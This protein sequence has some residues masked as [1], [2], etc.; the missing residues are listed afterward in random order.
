MLYE[1]VRN[2]KGVFQKIIE[3]RKTT[4]KNCGVNEDEKQ[5]YQQGKYSGLC[6]TCQR[7]EHYKQNKEHENAKCREYYHSQNGLLRMKERWF[8]G[9]YQKR[10]TLD[11]FSCVSCGRKDKL[12]IHHIDHSGIKSKGTYKKS[13]NNIENLITMCDSCH[14]YYHNACQRNKIDEVTRFKNLFNEHQKKVGVL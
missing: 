1:P 11:N 4:C 10:L 14:S 12:Q 6:V 13:N 8:G 5:I 2:N 3:G 7:I 9:N